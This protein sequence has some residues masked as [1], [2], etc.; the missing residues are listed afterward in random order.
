MRERS[1]LTVCDI[2]V[3]VVWTWIWIPAFEMD[4]GWFAGSDRG[5]MVVKVV[6]CGSGLPPLR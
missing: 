5:Y 4:H 6:S 3:E 1:A 2:V